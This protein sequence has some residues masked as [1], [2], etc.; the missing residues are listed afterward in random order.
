MKKILVIEDNKDNLTL[1]SYALKRAGYEV[2]SAE[3]GEEGVELAIKERPFFIIMD[4]GLPGID[5]FEATRRI[6]S[7]EIDGNIPIIAM[8]SFAMMGDRERVLSAGCN[9][10]F[11]KPIDPLTIVEKIHEVIGV[12][13]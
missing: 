9:G 2:I 10:Y 1:I 5:G 4:I 3:T 6:R 8:T 7:S 13:K 12:K 11:E